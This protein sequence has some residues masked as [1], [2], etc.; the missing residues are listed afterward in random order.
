MGVVIMAGLGGGIIDDTSCRGCD[1][2]RAPRSPRALG[3]GCAGAVPHHFLARPR[4]A[5]RGR[6]VLPDLQPIAERVQVIISPSPSRTNRRIGARREQ[7]VGE[8]ARLAPSDPKSGQ[9]SP[10]PAAS[11]QRAA[12]TSPERFR[13]RILLSPGKAATIA[14]YCLRSISI[15]EPCRS[16][17]RHRVAIPRRDAAVA[18]YLIPRSAQPRRFGQA[19]ARAGILLVVEQ[20]VD[21]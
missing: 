4:P 5:R 3:A 13:G 8:G 10:R 11:P 19:I 6:F 14:S 9:R 21:C 1:A 2:A 18:R 16:T 17:C 7:R 20:P 15:I 12:L